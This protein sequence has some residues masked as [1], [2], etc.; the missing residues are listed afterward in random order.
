MGRAEIALVIAHA[1]QV[2]AARDY[3]GNVAGYAI[4]SNVGFAVGVTG[5]DSTI[6]TGDAELTKAVQE[7]LIATGRDPATGEGLIARTRLVVVEDPFAVQVESLLTRAYSIP[8]AVAVLARSH[9][10]ADI[11]AASSA[12]RGR[13]VDTAQL[14]SLADLDALVSQLRETVDLT[15]IDAALREGV[16]EFADFSRDAT[17]TVEQFFSG[18]RVGPSHVGA[19]RDVVRVPECESILNALESSRQVLIVGASGTG[20]SGLLWRAASMLQGGPMLVRVLRVETEAD[21]QRLIRYVRVLAPTNDR[22]VL[23]CIDDLGRTST[24]L[25]PDARDRLLEMSGVSILGACRQEDLLPSIAT[26]ARLV[27]SRLTRE[28]AARIYARLRNTDIQLVAE[29]E[30]AIQRAEGLLMEFVAIATTGHRLREVL[31]A[32]VQRLDDEEDLVSLDVLGVI[33]ALHTLGR[34]V[35]ADDLPGLVEE[36]AGVISRRLTRLRDEHLVMTDDGTSWRALHDLR[37]EV[38]LEL[39]HEVP[40]PTLAA[41]Y[42]RSI[43]AAPPDVRPALYR[44][45]ATRV[46]RAA[47]LETAQTV[48]DRLTTAH[49]VIE[50]LV[51]SIADRVRELAT[52]PDAIAA[53]EIAALVDAAERLDVAAYVAASLGYMQQVTPPTTDVSSYY[54]MAYSSRFSAVFE[55]NTL[56]RRLIDI[57]ARLPEWDSSARSAVLAQVPDESIVQILA[58]TALD[59]AVRFSERLEG[60]RTVPAASAATVYARHHADV[61]ELLRVDVADVLAQLVATLAVVAELEGPAVEEAFGPVQQRATWAVEA[62]EA[63]FAVEVVFSDRGELPSSPS[64]LARASTY[65]AETFCEVSAKAMA[66]LPTDNVRR[67]YQPQA[68][69]DPM[70]LNAQAVFLAQRLFDACPEADVV[71]VEVVLPSLSS[72]LSGAQIDGVKRMRAGVVPRRITTER[73]IA[74]QVAVMELLSAERW[75]DRCRSQA[76]VSAQLVNLLAALPARLADRDSSRGRQEWTEQVTTTASLVARLPGLPVDR[77]LVERLS[78]ELP[79]AAD[80]DQKL[81]ETMRDPSKRALDLIAGSLLQVAQGLD[82]LSSLGGAGSRL[83]GAAQALAAGRADGTMPEYA[84]VGPLLPLELDELASMAARALVA[85]GRGMLLPED[86]RGKSLMGIDSMTSAMAAEAADRSRVALEQRLTVCGIDVLA[87]TVDPIQDPPDPLLHLQLTVVVDAASWAATE[88]ALRSWT[89]DERDAAGFSTR[90]TFVTTLHGRLVQI[91]AVLGSSSA[92]LSP[93]DPADYSDIARRLDLSLAS[94]TYQDRADDLIATLVAASSASARRRRRPDAW[95]DVGSTVEPP[96]VPATDDD[97]QPWRD[98]VI[99]YA[100]LRDI[101]ARESAA[102]ESLAASLAGVDLSNTDSFTSPIVQAVGQ[103]RALSIDADLLSQ[104]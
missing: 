39:L 82:D 86:I 98:A 89:A 14:R 45:A 31:R 74:V 87:I 37:A 73:S 53:V 63:G 57:G 54:L 38:L 85:R 96:D 26:G 68:G 46:L 60:Y 23:V 76:V 50:P 56:F 88:E 5:W 16:C 17:D 42:A 84:G 102:H 81:R 75:T 29:P 27:D 61:A 22:K 15:G 59:V 35:S 66:R 19:N 58:E 52:E 25:W 7:Q 24:E 3:D 55:G 18:V 44:R 77:Q 32:Q 99:I 1:G 47:R 6:P 93:I 13:A 69:Q 2:E 33:T 9:L 20:K 65:D 104:L 51:R 92:P 72:E 79:F 80:F 12:Q 100:G 103:L 95:P 41:T 8:P 21:V 43:A 30:E 11:A 49:R 10:A 67:G 48:A 94:S 28:S 101:V 64:N 83:A 91:G 62:D 4:V 40:P 34:S 36:P 90:T 97:P 78:A 71:S 70:A